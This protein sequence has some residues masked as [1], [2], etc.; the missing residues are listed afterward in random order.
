[1][2]GVTA[3]P[4]TNVLSCLIG[5]RGRESKNLLLCS[6]VDEATVRECDNPTR[7][8]LPLSGIYVGRQT[9]DSKSTKVAR[10]EVL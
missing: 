2:H 1:M 9:D 6:A 4:R 3:T 8:C 7:A 5:A 10:E